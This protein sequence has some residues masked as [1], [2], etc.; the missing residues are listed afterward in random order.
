MRDEASEP[1]AGLVPGTALPELRVHVSPAAN[2]RYF[3]AAGVSHPSLETGALYPPIAANLTILAFQQVHSAAV[4]QT[5]QHLVCHRRAPAG[6]D[7]VV[8]ATIGD[9]SDKRGRPYIDVDAT[10][11]TSDAPDAPLWTS[12]VTFTPV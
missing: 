3:R 5:R 8:R 6:T 10:I 12:Q 9:R 1:F 2:E 11:T 7:L 4:L